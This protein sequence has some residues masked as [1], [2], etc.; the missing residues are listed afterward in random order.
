MSKRHIYLE[1]LPL[2]EARA[3]LRAALMAAGRLAPLAGETVALDRALGRVT[4]G[5]VRAKLSSPHY[6]CAAMDG[7]AVAAADTLDARETLVLSLRLGRQAHAVNTGDPLP[8][9]TDAVIMIEHVN[10][11]DD[12]RLLIY[13]SVA[14]WQHVRL[15]GEDMVTTETVLQ[16]N[17]QLRPVDLGALAGCGHTTVEVRR[18]PRVTIIPTGGE[19]VSPGRPPERGQLIEYNSLILRGQI[20]E[21]GGQATTSEIV[22]DSL[23]GLRGALGD[24]L[25][26][27][28]DLILVL[29]GSSAGSHDF[30]AGAIDELGDLLVHGIAVRPGH[31]VIIGMIGTTPIIGVP[32]YPVSAALTG[33]LL[34]APL[35]RGWLGLSGDPP[36]TVEAVST[37]KIVSPLGDD[38]F[39]RVALAEID[40]RIQATPLQRGAGVITSLVQADGLAHIPRFHE[41]V[42]RGEAM[43]VSLY[44]PLSQIKSTIMVMGSHDPMLD[45]LATHLRLYAPAR[46]MIS[47][48]VGSIGGLIAL[49]RREAHLAGSHLFDPATATYNLPFT[50]KYL[51]DEPCQLVIFAQREQ[52]LILPPGN[53]RGISAFADIRGLRYVNRQRGAG[54]RVLFDHLLDRHHISPGEIAGY[55]RE[56]YTHL[57]VAAAVA[58]GIG[59][60]GMGLRSAAEAMGL[61]F[62][63]LTWE[64]FDLVIPERALESTG[65]QALLSV[66]RSADFKRELGA[67]S[68]Y[69]SD[70]TGQVVEV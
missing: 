52:G 42:D 44:R 53:P 16:V 8:D 45:L 3:R 30:T 50:R 5:P 34:I 65:L 9:N 25:D 47:V 18:K 67:Q 15:M 60:C 54:T 23:D 17:H 70:E 51:R 56:E 7:Y 33:E 2:D 29:S 61:D 6:H 48:N 43:R 27:A 21:A 59:D 32:G 49:R 69:R 26:A 40:G 22:D 1:D 46:R 63:G 13:A 12:G 37:R 55:E 11:T 64:R 20:R 28:P 35:I 39:L 14:P 36:V 41:G 57:G 38:D 66:L 4:A 10:Q 19:L 68:G 62:L 58:D 31:P 24:A